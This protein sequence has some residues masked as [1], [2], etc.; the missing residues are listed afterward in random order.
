[1]SEAAWFLADSC[2]FEVPLRRLSASMD[3]DFDSKDL[4]S[5]YQTGLDGER[6]DLPDAVVDCFVS[7]IHS[8]SSVT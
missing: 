6:A 4:D 2:S 5:R 7:G 3:N 1:M 8:G